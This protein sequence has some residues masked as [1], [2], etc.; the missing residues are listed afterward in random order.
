LS[1]SLADF[2]VKFGTS[3][4]RGLVGDLTADYCRTFIAA[5]LGILEPRPRTLLVGHDLRASS[6]AIAGYCFAAAEAS[7]TT[8]V[9]AGALP[10]PALALA[11]LER[12]CPAIMVTGSHIP[13][14]RNG[15]KAYRPDGEISKADEQAMLRF[16]AGLPPVPDGA[17]LPAADTDIIQRYAGRYAAAFPADALKGLR[18]GVYE[19]STVARDLF[20]QVLRS[21]G[22]TT[23]GLGRSATFLPVDTEAIRTE[24]QR[25]ASGWA[26]DG[27]FDAIVSADGDAD[28]PLVADERGHWVRGDVLGILSAKELGARTVVT[29]VSSNTALETCGAFAHTVRT[30]IGSPYVVAGMNQPGLPGPVAGYEANGG[31]LLG[32]DVVLGANML[33]ALPTRDAM[34]PVILV[35]AAAWRQGYRLSEL[36]KSLPPRFTAS[37]RLQNFAG[38]R[39]QAIIAALTA[40]AARTRS[41]MA[42]EAGCLSAVD[43]TDG[44]RV[45]FASGDIVHLRPSGNAPEL[46]CYAESSSPEAATD[47]CRKCLER[48]AVF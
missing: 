36:V 26:A 13:D 28:R 41:V 12:N 14:D 19:H 4:A 37:D 8:C 18:I 24:D 21:L 46:R 11:A 5:F 42:P 20:H 34:L 35:L 22:A 43:Q 40:D 27:T 2:R 44:Y 15:I 23:A 7:G 33:A 47:L 38:D 3:G 45:T 32:S 6:P 25:L 31:F 16:S 48:I 30:R 17:A 39:A 10:T 29:P 1:S 9:Y